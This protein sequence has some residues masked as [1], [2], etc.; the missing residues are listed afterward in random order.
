MD[1]MGWEGMGSI[2]HPFKG[3]EESSAWWMVDGREEGGRMEMRQMG[4]PRPEKF[5]QPDTTL[6]LPCRSSPDQERGERWE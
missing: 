3:E 2:S 4:Q 5:E 6:G 1:G